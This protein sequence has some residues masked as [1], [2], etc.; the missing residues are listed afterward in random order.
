MAGQARR[1]QRLVTAE[2]S[3]WTGLRRR[4]VSA[5]GADAARRYDAHVRA[6]RLDRRPAAVQ[7]QA[8]TGLDLVALMEKAFLAK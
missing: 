8:L 3:T 5:G 1:V 6:L 7:R 2:A 4:L